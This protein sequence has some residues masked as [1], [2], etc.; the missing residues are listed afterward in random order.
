M[1]GIQAAAYRRYWMVQKFL[2]I[3]DRDTKKDLHLATKADL[4][5][6]CNLAVHR[7]FPSPKYTA[8]ISF[9]YSAA[10][11]WM[12]SMK[13]S[14]PQQAIPSGSLPWYMVQC[15]DSYKFLQS[16]KG[17]MDTL[18]DYHG[19][20]GYPDEATVDPRVGQ[21]LDATEIRQLPFT[22]REYS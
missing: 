13:S 21:G 17:M 16:L 9:H 3:A 19:A 18:H 5:H 20:C 14:R 4:R 22:V 11:A 2:I 7:Y 10:F 6:I 1:K 12:V 15:V 8:L